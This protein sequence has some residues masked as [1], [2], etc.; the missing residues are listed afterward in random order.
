[1]KNTRE[2]PTVGKYREVIDNIALVAALQYR[3]KLKS[4]V[5]ECSSFE[6]YSTAKKL[7]N[8]STQ[9]TIDN[10]EAN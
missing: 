7:D 4:V 2:R 9:M 1:M 6:D 8:F 5:D 3:C 10:R